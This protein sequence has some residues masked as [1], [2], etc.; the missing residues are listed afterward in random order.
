M[1][2]RVEPQLLEPFGAIEDRDQAVAEAIDRLVRLGAGRVVCTCSTIGTSAE[3]A[4]RRA[5]IP[6]V[7]A[8]RPMMRAAARCVGSLAVIIAAPG[9]RSGTLAVLDEERAA[10]GAHG[11]VHIIDLPLAWTNFRSGRHE[12]YLRQVAIAARDALAGGMDHVV[13]AQL[14]MA[15]AAA[16]FGARVLSVPSPLLDDVAHLIHA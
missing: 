3:L 5:G 2:H 7:R 8:D 13:L 9:T 14:S 10:A 1:L 11:D 6:V 15:P 12:L 16:E 4:G